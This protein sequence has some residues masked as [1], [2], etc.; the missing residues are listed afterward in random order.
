VAAAIC[1]LSRSAA[2]DTLPGHELQAAGAVRNVGLT[3][4]DFFGFGAR[5]CTKDDHAGAEAVAGVV[6]EWAGADQDALGLELVNE[7]V[8]LGAE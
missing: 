1:A 7:L 6:E 5:G 2:G 4:G 3:V 8:M